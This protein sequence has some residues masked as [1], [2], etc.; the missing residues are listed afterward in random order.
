MPLDPSDGSWRV[1]V[2]EAGEIKCQILTNTGDRF[3][4]LFNTTTS[5]KAGLAVE[6]GE[7]IIEAGPVWTRSH[8]D[9]T[10]TLV[11]KGLRSV[12]AH[13]HVLPNAAYSI[14][15]TQ[16][17]IKDPSKSS[18]TMPNPAVATNLTGLSLG[19]IAKRLVQQA[20]GNPGG[21]LPIVFADD[22]AGGHERNF[23]G[24]SFTR[25]SEAL[26]GIEG[27]DGGVELR[28][29]PRFRPDML[30]VEWVLEVGSSLI[31]SPQEHR[32]DI[33][34]PDSPTRGLSW[35][36]DSSEMAAVA[37]AA[38]GRA[39]DKVLT[40][41]A[42]ST[43]LTDPPLNY[44]LLETADTGRS[45]VT[46]QA[47]MDAWAR[48]GLDK[49]AA[50]SEAWSFETLIDSADGPRL[51]DY[52][53]GDFMQLAIHGHE[54]FGDYTARQRIVQLSGQLGSEWVKVTGAP[55]RAA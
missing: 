18:G 20:L 46:E 4:D 17:Y 19:T 52:R 8:D 14:D 30:G 15:P 26:D 38:G 41:R 42:S 21:S 48:K 37:F 53:H 33:G 40:A 3:A 12:F 7:R 23:D 51:G 6:H 2:G 32:W 25:V 50:P 36:E 45:S 35:V 28:F 49:G 47:T 22:E 11:A 54:F 10:L 24:G 44:P 34:L 5:V 9:H 29:T 39:A 31:A 55:G 1:G 16:F 27:I 13:R 43:R